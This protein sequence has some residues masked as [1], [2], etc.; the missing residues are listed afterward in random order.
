MRRFK[1]WFRLSENLGGPGGGPDFTPINLTQYYQ[2][3]TS[4]G[5]GAFPNGGDEPPRPTKTPTE[6]YLDQKY[7]KF[8]KKAAKW[9]LLNKSL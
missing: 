1:E 5:A 3:I 7:R 2:A 4:K 8:M 9:P 6:K